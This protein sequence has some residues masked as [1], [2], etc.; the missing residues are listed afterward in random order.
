MINQSI[1]DGGRQDRS[2]NISLHKS[3]ASYWLSE[4]VEHAEVDAEPSV[5]MVESDRV[6]VTS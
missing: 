5:A 3:K 2:V 4:L 6:L 1:E